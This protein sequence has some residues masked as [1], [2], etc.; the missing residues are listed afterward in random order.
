MT[1]SYEK[2]CMKKLYENLNYTMKFFDRYQY[3]ASIAASQQNTW[4]LVTVWY[5]CIQMATKQ[6]WEITED[7]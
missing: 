3:S 5:M 6:C 1:E 7:N 4:C 2:S